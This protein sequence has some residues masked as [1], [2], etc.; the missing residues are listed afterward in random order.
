MNRRP[1]LSVGV[2]VGASAVA[3][4]VWWGRFEEPVARVDLDGAAASATRVARLGALGLEPETAALL[5]LLPDPGAAAALGARAEA[6]G[7]FG[8]EATVRSQLV[9]KLL[10]GPASASSLE[11]VRERWLHHVTLDF[12]GG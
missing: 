5:G 7:A 9:S 10:E 4:R 8:D 1:F 2:A 3:G 12:D 6:T 11:D